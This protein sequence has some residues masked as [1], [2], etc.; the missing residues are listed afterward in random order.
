MVTAVR[1]FVAVGRF[2]LYVSTTQLDK[3]KFL[4]IE[5]ERSNALCHHPPINIS[6]V[7]SRRYFRCRIKLL[8]KPSRLLLFLK[9]R[10]LRYV[11]AGERAHQLV[12]WY[13]NAARISVANPTLFTELA[14][15]DKG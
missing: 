3:F 9:S 8:S 11:S 12:G 4:C 6:S 14:R 1:R 10:H 15:I 13:D 2:R 7:F 5:E